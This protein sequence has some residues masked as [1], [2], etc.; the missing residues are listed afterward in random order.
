MPFWKPGS[1]SGGCALGEPALS[2]WSHGRE[3]RSRPQRRSFEGLCELRL[4]AGLDQRACQMLTEAPF[5][6]PFLPFFVLCEHV[7]WGRRQEAGIHP[8]HTGAVPSPEPPSEGT[9]SPDLWQGHSAPWGRGPCGKPLSESQ[10]ATGL[11]SSLSGYQA[12]LDL[13]C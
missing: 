8:R 11:S 4:P 2:R 3:S 12:L 9:P 7:R 13:R 6:L 5:W 1:W 10:G